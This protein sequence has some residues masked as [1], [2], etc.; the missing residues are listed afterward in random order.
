[1]YAVRLAPDA[2]EAAF[3]EAARGCLAAVLAP[4]DVAFVYTSPSP[5]ALFTAREPFSA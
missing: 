3:R 2:D 4:R 1:M 5:R